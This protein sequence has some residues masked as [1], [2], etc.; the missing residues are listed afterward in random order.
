MVEC[1]AKNIDELADKINDIN[2]FSIIHSVI[3]YNDKEIGEKVI[4]IIC[5]K[6]EVAIQNGDYNKAVSYFKEISEYNSNNV[7][8]TRA[9]LRNKAAEL[10]KVNPDEADRFFDLLLSTYSDADT[11]V[12]YLHGM[13]DDC[14]KVKN[15]ALAKK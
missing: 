15:V 14:L 13:V 11:Y 3:E 7:T 5:S 9:T 12:S 8:T 10:L 2:D 1:S 4:G 6:I